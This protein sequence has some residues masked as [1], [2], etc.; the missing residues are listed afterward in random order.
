VGKNFIKRR[1]RENEG[2]RGELW[3]C[4]VSRKKREER[5][6]EGN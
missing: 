1:G 3:E 2:T 6:G 5:A 4:E